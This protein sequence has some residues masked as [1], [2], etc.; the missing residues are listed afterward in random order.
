MSNGLSFLTRKTSLKNKI[1]LLLIL[2]LFKLDFL[3]LFF[4]PQRVGL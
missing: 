3:L 4:L 1:C 2:L